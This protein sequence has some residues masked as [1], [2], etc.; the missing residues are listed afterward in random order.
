MIGKNTL[1]KRSTASNFFKNTL[2]STTSERR[3]RSSEELKEEIQRKAYELYE[4]RGR[5]DGND[6]ADWLEA[7]RLV[8]T[9]RS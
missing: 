4:E 5:T 1:R 9:R 8:K 3:S 7:E 2:R 6:L